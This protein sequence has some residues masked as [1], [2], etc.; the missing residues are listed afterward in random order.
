MHQRDRT[1]WL[2][3]L[4]L[5]VVAAALMLALVSLGNGTPLPFFKR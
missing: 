5:L 2:A 3:V 4:I 1:D